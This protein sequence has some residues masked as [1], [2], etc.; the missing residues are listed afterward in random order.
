[1]IDVADFDGDGDLDVCSASVDDDTVAWFENPGE[2]DGRW[3]PRALSESLDG[4]R[5]IHAADLDGDG[6][7]DI[8]A[9]GWYDDRLL[10]FENHGGAPPVFTE[11]VLVTF[12]PAQ[13]PEFPGQVWRIRSGDV[14][15]DGD[16]DPVAVRLWEGVEWYE[17]DGGSP[18]SFSRRLIE[19][20]IAV[21]MGV[22]A[23]D[24]DQDG[25]V[26]ILVALLNAGEVSWYE[27][28]GGA[29]PAFV[30]HT[31]TQEAGGARSVM[32]GDLDGDGVE[33]V[34]WAGRGIDRIGWEQVHLSSPA[35]ARWGS[36]RGDAAPRR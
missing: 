29:P 14:D 27:N 16:L 7:P 23:D 17:N 18:P 1:M 5:A 19:G 9:G 31:L 30:E 28:L 21:G 34:I 20:N 6:D 10:W 15:G 32:T 26:D 12:P 22:D 11:R 36:A 4:A 13:A 25:D 24:L 33:D 35:G 8:V 2:P 3:I